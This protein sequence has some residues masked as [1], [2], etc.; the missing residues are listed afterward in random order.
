MAETVYSH[1][2]PLDETFYLKL[3]SSVA[4]RPLA[5]SR[6]EVPQQRGLVVRAPAGSL[7]AFVL[8]EG[9]QIVNV[10]F[11]NAHDPDER[12]WAE[13]TM[14]IE[15]SH[16]R[17]FTRLWGT[18]ARFRPLATVLEDTVVTLRRAGE[19]QSFH[20]FAHGGSGTPAD[21]RYRSGRPGVASTWERLVAAMS[22]VDVPAYALTENVSLFQKTAIDPITQ[23][24]TILPSDAMPGDRIV[25]FAEID[26][27][28]AVAAS[29]YREGGMPAAQLDGSTRPVFVEV[30]ENAAMPLGWPYPGLAYPNLSLYVD[31]A[32]GTRAHDVRATP[33]IGTST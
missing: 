2:R 17:R 14:L 9:R 33:G 12:Y 27:V 24:L 3:R 5:G 23:V 32:T 31:P 6:N 21:W 4:G 11:W 7:I 18:M 20:H 1:G 16:L 26:L 15:G 22:E 28:L 19:P 13:E 25:W 29:P 30:E 8:P 10:F